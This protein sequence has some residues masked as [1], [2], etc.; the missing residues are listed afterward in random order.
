MKRMRVLPFIWV[1]AALMMPLLPYAAAQSGTPESCPEIVQLALDNVNALCGIL[2]EGEACYGHVL[3]DATPHFGIDDLNFSQEGDIEELLKLRAIRLSPMDTL[4]GQWGVAMMKLR[5]YMDYADPEP[6]TF[7]LFGDIDIENNIERNAMI[8]ITAVAYSNVRLR[9]SANAGVI[10][11]LPPGQTT[12]ANGRSENNEWVRVALPDSGRVGW[13]Y[14][15]NLTSDEPIESLSIATADGPYF[16]PMQAFFLRSGV[17]D[18]ACPESPQ[19]GLLIQT[20]EG[21]AEITLLVNEVNIQLQATAYVQA[22]PGGDMTIGVLSGSGWVEAGGVYQPIFAGSQV[23]IPLGEDLVYSDAPQP[24]EP[25]EAETLTGLP[26]ELLDTP[27]EPAPPIS[28][29]LLDSLLAQ[30]EEALIAEL[31]GTSPSS[32]TTGDSTGEGAT[33]PDGL[34]PGLEGV[35]PPGMGGTPPGQGGTPP[36]LTK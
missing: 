1:V 22:D 25:Y 27:I 32:T 26:L 3:V 17:D 8:D 6:V 23:T 29:T 7:L 31:T 20:P 30:A 4:S 13:T 12:W 18:A 28:Q 16:G 21:V 2:G 14:V 19:S 36:G 35:V 33:A 5:A 34:P 11:V 10:G 9:P 24:P 15:P